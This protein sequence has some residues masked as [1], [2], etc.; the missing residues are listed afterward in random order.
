MQQHLDQGFSA[1]ALREK[2][3]GGLLWVGTMRFAAQIVT[4]TITIVV[5]RLLGPADF[6]VLAMATVLVGFLGLFA[7]AG[8]GQALV[9]AP[10][11]DELSLRRAFGAV[12]VI[13]C[14]LFAIC[15]A[16]ANPVAHFFGEQRL[17]PIVRVLA[18][19]FL[20]GILAV[21]PAALLTRL[22]DFRR[23]AM[24]GLGGS[25]FGSLCTLFLAIHGY[26]V[27]AL[28][29]GTL[30]ANLFNAIALNLIA[31]YFAG[32]LFNV[33]G[34]RKLLA[35]GSQ[36]TGTRLLWYL[37]SQS[38]L[39]IAG[40]LLGKEAV[41]LYSVSMHLAS[42]PVQKMSAILNQVTFPAFA[43]SQS[44]PELTVHFERSSSPKR[45]IYPN[46][47]G[48][49][50]RGPRDCSTSARRKMEAGNSATPTA[51]AHHAINYT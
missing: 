47:V 35:F 6:G 11:V 21:I 4:W 24:I 3:V 34:A 42:L 36:V 15:F 49:L 30:G 9:Q 37:Y 2:V 28:V 1:A 41:G 46:S 40:K 23:L 19:Q 26:G 12:I 5:I 33:S 51:A 32:P 27:W 39:L 20:I 31:P 45:R 29:A 10:Q 17:V 38:D 50:E 13:N 8:L 16:A 22:L 25:V 18:L 14:V 7:E 43:R 48:N 44:R